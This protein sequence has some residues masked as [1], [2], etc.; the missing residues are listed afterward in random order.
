MDSFFEVELETRQDSQGRSVYAGR[1]P[2]GSSM[3]IQWLTVG[4]FAKRLF[5][6]HSLSSLPST[7]KRGESTSWRAI[8]STVCLPAG[9]P[10]P[11]Q[12]RDTA[13]AVLFEATLPIESAQTSWQR[14]FALAHGQ[15]LI[16]GV[17]P[18]FT[19]PPRG[20]VPGAER[21]IPEPGNPGVMIRS[22]GAAVLFEVSAVTRPAYPATGL[23][24][25]AEELSRPYWQLD[26]EM[27]RW[28]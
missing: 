24:E 12:I 2:Y 16:R 4:L 21:L 6:S 13:E 20:V 19:V 28:L 22:I 7:T 27:L 11:S 23:E 17:S 5:E 14:D 9:A 10:V 8:P 25:R 1:F 18:G 15:G 26:R 3:A